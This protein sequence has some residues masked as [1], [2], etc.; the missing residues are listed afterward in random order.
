VRSALIELDQY[1]PRVD[2]IVRGWLPG[3]RARSLWGVEWKSHWREPM[4]DVRRRHDIDVDGVERLMSA[5]TG[6]PASATA[7]K[8]ARA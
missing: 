6:R 1:E 2:A 5:W 3:R 8:D 7:P 4:A